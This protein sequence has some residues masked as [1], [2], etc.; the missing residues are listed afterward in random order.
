MIGYWQSVSQA[1]PQARVTLAAHLGGH[2][3]IVERTGE[4]L[5]RW[6]VINCLG[7]EIESGTAP[8]QEAAEQ[9]AEDAAFH[10]HPPTTGD[11]VKRLI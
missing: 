8:G 5:W 4:H 7:H 1:G 9:M 2:E 6:A 3:L 11:W 10:I